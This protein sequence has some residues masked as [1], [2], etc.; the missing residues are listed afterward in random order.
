MRQQIAKLGAEG[1]FAPEDVSI[2][3]AAFDSAW[4][5]VRSSGAPFSE[6]DYEERARAIIAK[7]IIDAAT[8]GER[9]PRVLVEGALMRLSKANLRRPGFGHTSQ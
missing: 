2:L 9:D 7:D 4:A 6:P 5:S 3:V 1:V 8:Q